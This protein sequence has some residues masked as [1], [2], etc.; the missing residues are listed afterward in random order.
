MCV[1]VLWCVRACTSVSVSESNVCTNVMCACMTAY[2]PT[3][4]LFY[5]DSLGPRCPLAH[6]ASKFGLLPSPTSPNT[7]HKTHSHT[8]GSLHPLQPVSRWGSSTPL[9]VPGPTLRC[10]R[11]RHYVEVRTARERFFSF[12]L[13]ELA[14]PTLKCTKDFRLELG[15]EKE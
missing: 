8:R 10:V 13:F 1:C 6:K 7:L 15:S 14:Q 3:L 4:P 5:R 9:V 12:L 11:Y 2:S